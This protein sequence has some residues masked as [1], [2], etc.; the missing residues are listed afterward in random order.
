MFLRIFLDVETFFIKFF[1]YPH[2]AI[3][4]IEIRMMSTYGDSDF[5]VN[6]LIYF[7]EKISDDLVFRTRY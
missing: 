1:L 2:L 4:M 7:G 3:R 5:I 6:I